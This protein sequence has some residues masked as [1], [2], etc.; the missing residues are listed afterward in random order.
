M[1][2][3]LQPFNFFDFKSDH[4]EI[5]AFK[6]RHSKNGYWERWEKFA[7]SFVL[8]EHENYCSIELRLEIPD[9]WNI[10]TP[11]GV[12]TTIFSGEKLTEVFIREQIH[13]ENGLNL[14]TTKTWPG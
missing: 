9:G 8:V 14:E 12:T 4:P 1:A 2:I 5:V 11:N 3:I 7:D 13:P 6:E 10:S